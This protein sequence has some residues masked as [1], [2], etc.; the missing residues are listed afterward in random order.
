MTSDLLAQDGVVTDNYVKPCHDLTIK[1]I[2]HI[3]ICFHSVGISQEVLHGP[4]SCGKQQGT[5][6]VVLVYHMLTTCITDSFESVHM[7]M[8]VYTGIAVFLCA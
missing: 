6:H 7:M 3:A 2:L 5:I 4:K 8:S 1:P